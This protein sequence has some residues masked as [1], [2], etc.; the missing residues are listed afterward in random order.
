MDKKKSLF[1]ALLLVCFITVPVR[2]SSSQ[3]DYEPVLAEEHIIDLRIHPSKRY[4]EFPETFCES[5]REFQNEY[6]TLLEK[7]LPVGYLEKFNLAQEIF[8]KKNGETEFVQ[9]MRGIADHCNLD[10]SY[11]FLYNYVYELM[12][13]ACTSIIFRDDTGILRLIGNLDYNYSE[14]YSKITF[15]AIYIG[16]NGNR[17]AEA[18]QIFGFIGF[19]RGFKIIN[20]NRISI[21]LNARGIREETTANLQKL[22]IDLGNGATPQVIYSLRKGFFKSQSL[23]ELNDL[24]SR[25]SLSAPAYYIICDDSN[26]F[27]I[28]KRAIGV[29]QTYNLKDW[30]LVQT[31]I[32]TDLSRRIFDPRRTSAESY[33][34]TLK[35]GMR[36]P[37]VIFKELMSISPVFMYQN[38]YIYGL[39][40]TISS[41]YTKD[42]GMVIWVWIDKSDNKNN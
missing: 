4:A 5:L 3:F 10:Y 1:L 30:F 40:R 35:V 39:M 34:Q 26:G 20:G 16:E 7:K 42:D 23:N 21:A 37:E 28:E 2:G 12:E 31:N 29:H 38:S 36:S 9:E 41:S 15:K 11:I 6:Y 13:L 27:V 17:I 18:S 24:I 33:L 22:L 19:S 32:D 14:T 25:T 8:T